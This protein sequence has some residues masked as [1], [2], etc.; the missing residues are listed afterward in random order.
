MIETEVPL[1]VPEVELTQEEVRTLVLYF[2]GC[3]P[4]I[5]SFQLCHYLVMMGVHLV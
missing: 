2:K 1:P 4:S 5:L 3:D